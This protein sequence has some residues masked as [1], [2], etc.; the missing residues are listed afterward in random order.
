MDEL[1]DR[2]EEDEGNTRWEVGEAF[3]EAWC[4][5]DPQRALVQWIEA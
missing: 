1:F 2:V 5:L 4:N 3:G